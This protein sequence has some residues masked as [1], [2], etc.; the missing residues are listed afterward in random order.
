MMRQSSHQNHD[1]NLKEKSAHRLDLEGDKY[2]EEDR[3]L[4]IEKVNTQ[5]TNRHRVFSDLKPKKASSVFKTFSP[6]K[7]RARNLD[8]SHNLKDENQ[9]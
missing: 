5:Q 8:M 6:G 7:A 4:L 9:D 2:S 3:L 1:S